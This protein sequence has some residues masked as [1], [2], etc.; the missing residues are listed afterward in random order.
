[1]L[2]GRSRLG[3]SAAPNSVILGRRTR[4]SFNK[5]AFIRRLF[6]PRPSAARQA[7]AIVFKVQ[8][9]SVTSVNEIAC[10]RV[11]CGEDMLISPEDIRRC[12][13][14]AGRQARRILQWSENGFDRRPRLSR[15]IDRR[16]CR[17]PR[18]MQEG[19]DSRMQ[20]TICSTRCLARTR[21]FTTSEPRLRVPRA[22]RG[23]RPCQSVFTKRMAEDDISLLLDTPGSLEGSVSGSVPHRG[24]S[25]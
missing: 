15:T 17:A 20:R 8:H 11:S 25:R 14:H 16:L 9:V 10:A 24:A 2:P 4:P 18:P 1:M 22:G 5:T 21:G 12:R 7:C 23:S 3:I 13:P 6:R 19:L